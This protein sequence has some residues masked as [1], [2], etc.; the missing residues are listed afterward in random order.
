MLYIYYGND[1]KKVIAGSQKMIEAMKSKREFAQVFYFYADSFDKEIV[2]SRQSAQ[3]LF[4]DKHI[5]VFKNFIESKKEVR[6]YV[7]NNIQKFIDSNHMY[8]IIENEIDDKYLGK[9][10]SCKD[11][12]IKE[13]KTKSVIKEDNSKKLF[14]LA[15]N[16]VTFKSKTVKNNNDKI[17][18]INQ[19][20]EIK[21]SKTAAEEFFGILWWRYKK[22]ASHDM[23]NMKYLLDIYQDGHQMLLHTNHILDYYNTI[24]IGR[25]L[26]CLHILLQT[27]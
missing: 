4:F 12:N 8:I 5:F 15:A 25:Q 16:I 13:Y 7:L 26:F 9:I 23:K 21:Q 2:E 1:I 14:N 24:R 11:I 17:N 10:L 27:S 6:D 18:I 3:G 20:D 19:I 22:Y